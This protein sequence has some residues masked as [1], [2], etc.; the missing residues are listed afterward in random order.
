MELPLC[1]AS[2]LFF[3]IIE[4]GWLLFTYSS[5]Y[6]GSREG[7]RYGAATGTTSAGVPAYQDC[8]GI[9][10]AALRASSS[11][12]LTASNVTVK[13]SLDTSD[14]TKVWDG[15]ATSGNFSTLTACSTS[16]T[17]QLGDRLLVRVSYTFNMDIPLS[18]ITSVPI[19][20]TSVR[21]IVTGINIGE[22]ITYNP[23]P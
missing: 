5:I 8:N 19:I 7:V 9:K 20:T 17:P 11:A 3:G 2:L 10:T 6:A 13:Y 16:F 23:V 12:G 15:N 1:T 4:F 22:T 14:S 18:P 21:T